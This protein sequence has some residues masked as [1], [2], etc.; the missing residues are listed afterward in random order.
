[1]LMMM[2]IMDVEQ[3]T[4]ETLILPKGM[5]EIFPEE[6]IQSLKEIHRRKMKEL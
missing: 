2:G 5:E 4:E 3:L 6:M 1:M